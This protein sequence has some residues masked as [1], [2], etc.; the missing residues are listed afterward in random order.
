MGRRKYELTIDCCSNLSWIYSDLFQLLI[1][2]FIG[3]MVTNPFRFP[4]TLSW[5]S[6]CHIGTSP[7]VVGPRGGGGTDSLS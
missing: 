2:R 5:L 7:S 1:G 3:N 6:L 4:G